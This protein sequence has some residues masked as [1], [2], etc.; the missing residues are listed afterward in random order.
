MNPV[1]AQPGDSVEL[2]DK[3]TGFTDPATGFDISRDQTVKLGNTIGEKTHQALMSG[4]LLV[5]GSKS[6][7]NESGPS[8]G[9]DL[10]ADM[11]GREAFVAAGFTTFQSV[12]DLDTDEK[13]LAVK[14]IGP[15]TVKSLAAWAAENETD[16]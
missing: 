11:P 10:P 14:G 4:A 7:K 1:T 9:F 12:K 6:K 13:L 8:D 5:V 3:E 2:K 16:D 15:G